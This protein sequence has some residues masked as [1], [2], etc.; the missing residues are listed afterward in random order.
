LVSDIFILPFV[1]FSNSDRLPW[2]ELVAAQAAD[3]GPF[4]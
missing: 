2:A 4:A 3:P 1:G